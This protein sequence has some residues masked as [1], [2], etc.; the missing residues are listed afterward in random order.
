MSGRIV[1]VLIFVAMWAGVTG[2][3]DPPNLLF[4]LA[5]G[6]VA[7]WL[8]RDPDDRSPRVR[9]LLAPALLTSAEKDWWN[10]YH[11][12]VAKALAPQLNGDA[13]AW[14]LDACLPL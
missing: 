9:P 3:V 14:L 12:R 4:G 8:V 5:L 7:L 13:L 1:I 10:V 2:S 6:L 11:A